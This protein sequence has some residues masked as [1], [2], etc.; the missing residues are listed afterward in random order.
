M[1]A[2]ARLGTLARMTYTP[3]L[4]RQTLASSEIAG[5]TMEGYYNRLDA[6]YARLEEMQRKGTQYSKSDFLGVIHQIRD[7]RQQNP[8]RKTET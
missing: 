8:Y 3:E 6:L 4:S 5:L 1:P 2:W 7:L